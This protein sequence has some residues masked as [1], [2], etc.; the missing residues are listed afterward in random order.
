VEWLSL[1][2]SG[3]ALTISAVCAILH[4]GREARGIPRHINDNMAAIAAL[5]KQA[6]VLVA[7]V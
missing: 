6:Q 3:I 2:G 7:R 4:S 1:I 5:R